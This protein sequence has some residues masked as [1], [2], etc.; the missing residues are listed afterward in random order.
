MG[1]KFLSK[2]STEAVV[3]VRNIKVVGAC[4]RAQGQSFINVAAVLLLT[5]ITALV[6][7][8][9]PEMVPS[10]VAKINAS[11]CRRS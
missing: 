6:P 2:T 3:E 7:E 1:R 8:L 4:C 5:A 10:S 11:S 9:H